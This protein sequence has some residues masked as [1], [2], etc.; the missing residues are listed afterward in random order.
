MLIKNRV[1][2]NEFFSVKKCRFINLVVFFIY[3][4]IVKSITLY[5]NLKIKQDEKDSYF[6][7]RNGRILVGHVYKNIC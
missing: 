4:C 5:F 3:I 1:V 2:L 6:M 7:P